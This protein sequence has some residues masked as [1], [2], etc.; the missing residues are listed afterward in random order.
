MTVLTEHVCSQ[1]LHCYLVTHVILSSFVADFYEQYQSYSLDFGAAII[2]SGSRLL[3]VAAAI[4]DYVV[5]LKDAQKPVSAFS[6]FTQIAHS[7]AH[8]VIVFVL[9]C[10]N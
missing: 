2:N 6:G 3:G 8:L 5:E 1:A 4:S 9:L 10:F 7:L